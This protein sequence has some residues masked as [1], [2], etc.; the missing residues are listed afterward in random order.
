M[1]L[2]YAH[3]LSLPLGGMLSPVIM[4]HQVILNVTVSCLYETRFHFSLEQELVF[5]V[6]FITL[7]DED[8]KSKNCQCVLGRQQVSN[9]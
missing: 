3:L 5:D 8:I 9:R 4:C 2:S 1:C 7:C 6:P